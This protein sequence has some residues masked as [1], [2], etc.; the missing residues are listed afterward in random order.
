MI[1]PRRCYRETNLLYNES[2]SSSYNH[3]RIA[4]VVSHELAHQW[5]GNLVTLNWWDD[6]WLNEGFASYIEYKGIAQYHPDWDIVSRQR[7]RTWMGTQAL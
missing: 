3:Q 6:L 5:F 4:A 7:P 2:S 1:Y